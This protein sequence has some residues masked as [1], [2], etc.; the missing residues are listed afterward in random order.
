MDF[1][2][3]KKLYKLSST[4][5]MLTWEVWV[6]GNTIINRF[7]Q[8]G[9]KLQEAPDTILVGKNIGTSRE[10][11]PEQ[12]ALLEAESRWEKQQKHKG[13]VIDRDKAEAG[14]RLRSSPI[15]MLAFPVQQE[16]GGEI[17]D[18]RHRIKYP[19]YMQPKLDGTRLLCQYID[20]EVI[21]SARTGGVWNSLP[22]LNRELKKLFD[23]QGITDVILDG[24]AYVHKDDDNFNE[25]ISI[26]K[27]VNQVHPNHELIQYHVYD[28]QIPNAPFSM[29]TEALRKIIPDNHPNIKFVETR[30]AE[31]EEEWS[32]FFSECIEKA[33]EGIILRNANGIYVPKRSYD[34]LKVKSFTDDEF[35][36]IGVEPG[37][38]KFA[39]C[40]MFIC[41][42]EN[43]QPGHQEFK[44]NLACPLSERK[45][46]LEDENTWKGKVLTIRYQNLTEYGAPRCLTG[47]AIRDYEPGLSPRSADHV[48]AEISKRSKSTSNIIKPHAVVES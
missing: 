35:P 3:P 46:Y 28:I 23:A 32:A 41:W 47:R 42:A 25:I 29:R 40:A 16:R 8:E 10:T 2:Q 33:Y 43:A 12:Q 26:V 17:I 34:L 30:M 44:A 27:Q 21:L 15:P 19:V 22:H 31:T 13:Y 6:D 38:G 1:T 20:G 48:K 45:Q 36:I 9:G 39:E 5:K 37:R 7:G 4:G 14:Q 11:T 24:E 18:N